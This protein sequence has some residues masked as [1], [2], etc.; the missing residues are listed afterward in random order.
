VIRYESAIDLSSI[1]AIDMH[2]HIE[3]DDAGHGSLPAELQA[4]MDRYF[5]NHAPM[6]LDAVAAYYRERSMAAVVFTVDART[7]LGVIPN[8]SEEIAEGAARNNDVLI[9]FGSVDPLTGGE[10]IELAKRLHGDYGVR[11]FKFHPSVQGFDPSDPRFSPLWAAIQDFGV[12]I[13]VHTGQTGV[14]AGAPGGFGIKLR[15]SN[16]ML[17]DDVAADFP[18]LR[19]IMAHPSTP[20]QDEAISIATHKPNAFIDLS[21]WSPKYFAPQLVRNINSVLRDKVMFGSDFPAI[22]PDRWLHDF[23]DLDIKDAVRPKVLKENAVALLG[24]A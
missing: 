14:G 19:I 24:L 11:G 15:Y 7:R 17:L 16:P 10:A 21:G 9:P 22:T 1:T 2:V 3:V 13:V 23:A 5:G 12:P 8:S 18:E 20:W 4:A 6:P